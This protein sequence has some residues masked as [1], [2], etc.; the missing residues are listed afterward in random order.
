LTLIV[1]VANP[2]YV[3]QIS[4]RRLSV[5]GAVASD[6]ANKAGSLTCANARGAFGYTGLASA[7][8]FRTH[9]WLLEGLCKLGSPDHAVRPILERLTTYATESFAT[10]PAILRC[11]MA[12]RRLTIMFTG[13]LYEADPP[14]LVQA[15]ITNFQD[16]LA[17]IDSAVCWPEF[18]GSYWIERRPYDQAKSVIQRIGV[19]P[20]TRL[21]DFDVLRQMAES[22]KPAR[23]IV[24]KAFELFGRI[25]ARPRA[26]GTIGPQL[27]AVVVPSNPNA[28]I[29]AA[30]YTSVNSSRLFTPSAVVTTPALSMAMDELVLGVGDLDQSSGPV[31]T[32]PA[33]KHNA[34][35]PCGSGK[36]YRRCH[37]QSRYRKKM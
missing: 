25:A 4:D 21:N 32:T 17:G 15:I 30:Y 24:G 36:K 3:V 16:F 20:A 14:V 29:E 1:A 2:A 6:E 13:F 37:G 9:R 26:H 34:P 22:G 12:E 33:A 18:R 23:A 27:S 5:V 7:Y 11:G 10:V 8:G 19:W 31:I 35:C 28:P